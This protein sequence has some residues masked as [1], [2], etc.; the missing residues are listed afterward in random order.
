[1]TYNPDLDIDPET[2][3]AV[4]ESMRIAA[5]ETYHR[6]KKIKLPNVKVHAILHAVVENQLALGQPDMVR[7]VFARLRSEG[8]TRH[9]AVHAIGTVVTG[10]MF[11]LL[12]EG[13]Q[14]HNTPEAYAEKLGRLTA[15]SWRKMGED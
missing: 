9:E 7:Y 6:N 10:Q 1:M 4:D 3:L 12:K 5:A 13:H 11:S 8:L 14:P 2:W 15:E